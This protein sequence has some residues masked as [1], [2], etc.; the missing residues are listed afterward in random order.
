MPEEAVCVAR[1]DVK[2]FC[3]AFEDSRGFEVGVGWGEEM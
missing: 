2:E 1:K 3:K